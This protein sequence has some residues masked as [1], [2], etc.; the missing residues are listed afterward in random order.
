MSHRPSTHH[1]LHLTSRLCASWWAALA[2]WADARTNLGVEAR[3]LGLKFGAAV[4]VALEFGEQ[5]EPL[6]G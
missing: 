2:W 3:D 4:A 1:T 6:P 5:L